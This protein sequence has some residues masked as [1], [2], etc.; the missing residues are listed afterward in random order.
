[1][2]NISEYDC[3]IMIDVMHHIHSKNQE[4][5]MS[6]LLQNMKEHSTFIYKDMS[7]RNL[8]LSFMNILHDLFST[9][10]NHSLL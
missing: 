9:F 2:N 8:F 7:N 10:F 5:V 3:I 1:M 6:K 4:V